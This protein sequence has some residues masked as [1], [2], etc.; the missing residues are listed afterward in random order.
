M[1]VHIHQFACLTDNYGVLVHDSETGATA[2]IDVPDAQ[3]VL[4]ALEDKG[5]TLTD[6]LVTH[7]H[8]DHIQGITGVKAR[9]PKARVI[10]PQK[11][12]ARIPGLEIGLCENDTINIGGL[13]ACVIETPGHTTGHI[14]YWFETEDMLFAGDTLFAMGCG[15][16][17]ETPMG[18]MWTSLMKLM[19]LPG[20]TQ[21]WCGHEYGLANARFALTIEPGNPLLQHRAQEVEKL[22]VAGH[23]AVPT[24][25][26]LEMA[27]NPFLRAD[28]ASV[29]ASLGMVG[30]DPAAVFAEIRT[31]KNRA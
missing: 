20:E 2:S 16:V 8:T 1:T 4:Q 17:L 25:L 7:H 26:A 23:P 3:A 21:V 22:V 14:V 10:G 5:W 19:A 15:R 27:T 9:L 18:V 12:R 31:R 29:Q 30:A 24:T 28:E 11:D 6:I 13:E